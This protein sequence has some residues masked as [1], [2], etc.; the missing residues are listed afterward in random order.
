MIIILKKSVK[1]GKSVK[2][3]KKLQFVCVSPYSDFFSFFFRTFGLS[4]L[5]D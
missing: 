3:E 1:S 5:S 4:G 2:S